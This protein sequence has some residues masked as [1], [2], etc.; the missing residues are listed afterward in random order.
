[1]EVIK[2]AYEGHG[3]ISEEGRAFFFVSWNVQPIKVADT[4]I[5]L[6]ESSTNHQETELN[7]VSFKSQEML[8]KQ[9]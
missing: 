2:K 4:G 9:T 7:S 3:S 6:L 8:G 1:M 5:S